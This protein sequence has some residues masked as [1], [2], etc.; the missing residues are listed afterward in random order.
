MDIEQKIIR[1]IAY[2]TVF[3]HPLTADEVFAYLWCRA[4]ESREEVV[5]R[6]NELVKAGK[7]DFK[8]GFYFFAGNEADVEKRRSAVV[9][10]DVMLRRARTAKKILSVIPFVEAI[11]VCNSVAA[12]TANENSDIDLFIVT[13]PGR[14]WSVRF[15]SNVL[16]LAFG[17][18]TAKGHDSGR[19]C[20][21]FFV[22]ENNLD[23]GGMRVAEDDVYLVY[24]LRQILPV[25]DPKNILEKIIEKNVWANI[26]AGSQP[27]LKK[28]ESKCILK[29]IAEKILDAGAGNYLEKKLQEWQ[30]KKLRP[31]LKAKIKEGSSEVVVSGGVLKFHE[32]DA[33][34]NI[35]EEWTNIFAKYGA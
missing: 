21:S 35:R 8:Y 33:R 2:F 17:L 31:E 15:F 28:T 10:G 13:R 6:L 34:I 27:V 25:F 1:T 22:D 18:R 24:W 19:V 4:G 32:N 11:F 14:I 29:K 7:L 5:G 9:P 20:L 16:M 12:E 3:R 30:W 26:Y 23:I